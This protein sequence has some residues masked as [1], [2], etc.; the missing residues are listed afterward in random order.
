MEK[1]GVVIPAYNCAETIE[2]AIRSILD[3]TL[4]PSQIIIVDH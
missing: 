1:Y 3:Q 2:E 4:P